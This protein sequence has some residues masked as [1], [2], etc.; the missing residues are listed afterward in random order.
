MMRRNTGKLLLFASLAISAIGCSSSQCKDGT[1][2]SSYSSGT[3]VGGENSAT[4]FGSTSSKT[5][6]EA[7]KFECCN[8]DKKG[9]LKECGC[10]KQCP[11]WNKHPAQQAAKPLSGQSAA[12]PP[13]SGPQDRMRMAKL[14]RLEG[15]DGKVFDV[16]GST[17]IFHVKNDCA[18]LSADTKDAE[19]IKAV[20]RLIP[21]YVRNG[22]L[23]DRDGMYYD[24]AWLCERCIE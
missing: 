16:S 19:R 4:G 10:T 1:S 7:C 12:P 3:V 24:N 23:L 11:C 2:S 20:I 15:A 22:R 5:S 9:K 14:G 18:R 21:V 17:P 13:S 8:P 6:Y